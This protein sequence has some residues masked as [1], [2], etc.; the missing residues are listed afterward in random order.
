MANN[1]KA[2]NGFTLI[3][4]LVV[5]SIISILAAL[6]LPALSSA[7][8]KAWRT[9]CASNLKQ[10]SLGLHLYAIDNK[11]I[12]PDTPGLTHIGIET[13]HFAIFYK[14]MIRSYVGLSGPDPTFACPADMFYYNFPSHTYQSQSLHAQSESDYSSYGFN[15]LYGAVTSNF[16]AE[17]LRDTPSPGVNGR[18][19]SSIKFPD[20]TLL[21]TETSA[22]FPFSWHQP[23]RLLPQDWGVKD[24]KNTVG[25]VDG[26]ANYIKIFWNTN[27]SNYTG[28][29]YNPPTGYD[30][31]WSGE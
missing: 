24:A 25:F 7:K 27:F 19:L 5:I 21:V 17:F 1:P 30:Y 20:R 22:F 14:R 11:D 4:L 29:C 18:K 2:A 12:L 9:V 6:L 13:N 23:Q 3:E 8:S 31:T 10:I 16:P 15:G 26:H 28:C